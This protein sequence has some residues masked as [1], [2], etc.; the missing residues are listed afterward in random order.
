[1]KNRYLLITLVG[2][3]IIYLIIVGGLVLDYLKIIKA[4]DSML[5]TLPILI[6]YDTICSIMGFLTQ[7][8][9]FDKY[10][11]F[12][13]LICG[14]PVIIFIAFLLFDGVTNYF[15]GGLQGF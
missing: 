9:P 12:A 1:M 15:T 8:R 14:T 5:Y 10:T 6:I 2:N 3:L 11:R 4:G 7:R 13:I